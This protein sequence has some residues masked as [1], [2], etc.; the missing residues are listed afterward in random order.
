M[1][2]ILV[3]QDVQSLFISVLLNLTV[4]GEVSAGWTVVDEVVFCQEALSSGIITGRKV[5]LGQEEGI[6][7]ISLRGTL[8][9]YR[10][11]GD[12]KG[13]CQSQQ[14]V[15]YVDCRLV[16]MLVHGVLTPLFEK[17]LHLLKAN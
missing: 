10:G 15:S 4:S 3:A 16:L 13:T 8:A 11:A 14:L 9:W 5:D 2:G 6:I 12:V 17:L 7:R 1:A